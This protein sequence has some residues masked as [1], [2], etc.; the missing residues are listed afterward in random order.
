M[1]YSFNASRLVT[2]WG[3]WS[4]KWYGELMHDEAMLQA[5]GITLRI[6]LLSATAATVLGTFFGD[7]PGAR[8]PVSR[9][10][11]VLRHGLCTAGD[12]GGDHRPVAL[13]AVRRGRARSRFWT[14]TIAHTTLTMC[15]VAV[16]VQSRLITFDRSL[17]EAAFD[18]GCPPLRT[19]LTVT[20]R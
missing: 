1:I 20:C 5:A 10:H 15:F 17:E 4:L 3:G 19:F 2:I 6:A 7:R 16:V 9:P 13:A 18:L 8:R 11:A 12:A 14:V